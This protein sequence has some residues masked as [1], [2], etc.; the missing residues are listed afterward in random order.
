M[1]SVFRQIRQKA[2]QLFTQ[3]GDFCRIVESLKTLSYLDFFLCS[4]NQPLL[5]L[6]IGMRNKWVASRLKT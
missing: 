6:E 1:P 2:S 3:I 4:M 5:R